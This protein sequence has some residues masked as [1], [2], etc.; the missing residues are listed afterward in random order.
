MSLKV[1]SRTFFLCLGGTND[2]GWGK[3]A[4]KVIENLEKMYK[5]CLENDLILIAMTIPTTKGKFD[6]INKK[7]NEINEYIKTFI[8][9]NGF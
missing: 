4:K 3:E 8:Q 5:K 9:K 6:I 7:R 1:E 2:I